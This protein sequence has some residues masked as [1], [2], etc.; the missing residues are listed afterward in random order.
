MRILYIARLFDGLETS[1]I[2]RVWNPAGV[3]TSYKLIEALDASEHGFS[4]VLTSKDTD[5][6]WDRQ[7]DSRLRI[8]GLATSVH[9]LS[10]VASIPKWTGRFREHLRD[11]RHVLKVWRIARRWKPDLV[12]V[13]HANLWV[14]A[15]FARFTS[16]PAVLRIMGIY[17][18]MRTAL[19]STRPLDRVARWA[20]RSPWAAVIATQDG[21]GVETWL[22][23]AVT[24]TVPQFE[25]L[26]GVDQA[27]PCSADRD[28]CRGLRSD[29][30]VVSFV[31][32]LH[33]YKG[34]IEFVEGFLRA[35]KIIGSE[36]QAVVVGDGPLLET[37]RR[38]VVEEG[39]A[40]AVVFTG[41]LPHNQ[42]AQIQRRADIY[43]SLNRFGNLS[44]ANL[45]A[46]RAGKCMIIP[47]AA[48]G[49]H[50]DVATE[51]LVP[52]DAVWRVPSVDDVGALADALLTLS[53][54]PERRERMGRTMAALADELLPTWEVRV[55]RELEI[56]ERVSGDR[57]GLGSRR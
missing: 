18:G 36:L 24:P 6:Q 41:R 51:R 48:I 22:Q 4:L 12:Y 9:V 45:E 27:D 21:S 43:V 8:A 34:C 38:R 31:A 57:P 29:S 16:V 15:F 7:T 37:M 47:M 42:V 50:V 1:I 2:T 14:G 39:A 46:M 28:F 44:N 5:S 19:T 10:G 20:Y 53:R 54:E 17:P 40:D 32:R 30:T 23:D 3:P 33:P 56:L 25:L 13:G 11:L 55:R 49:G 26:N 52:E 35:W